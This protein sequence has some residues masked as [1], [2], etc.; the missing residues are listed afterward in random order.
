VTSLERDLHYT[1]TLSRWN[2]TVVALPAE[3][4]VVPN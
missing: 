3:A 2:A 4:T 1:Y